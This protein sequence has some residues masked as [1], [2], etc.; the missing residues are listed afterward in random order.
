[1][2]FWPGVKVIVALQLAVPLPLAVPPVA[3]TPLTVTEETPLLPR[4]LSV[5]VPLTSRLGLVSAAPLAGEL[6]VTAGPWAEDCCCT[7]TIHMYAPW[8]G[9]QVQ[10][11]LLAPAAETSFDAVTPST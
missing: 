1:M 6:M 7:A 9:E 3:L 11:T 8:P 10:V 2:V 5:A 4:P